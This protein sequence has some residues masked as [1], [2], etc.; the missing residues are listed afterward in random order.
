M[1]LRLFPCPAGLGAQ[2]LPPFV[3]FVSGV[4]LG[5]FLNPSGFAKKN[6]SLGGWVSG[7]SAGQAGQQAGQ[8]EPPP[9][10]PTQGRQGRHL[11]AP[12]PTTH[13]TPPPK[14]G[15]AGD[16][17]TTPPTTQGRQS[18]HHQ[19]PKPA[20]RAIKP[21]K[22]P[23]QRSPASIAP[24]PPKPAPVHET[25]CFYKGLLAGFNS[26]THH[27]KQTTTPQIKPA[28]R[29]KAGRQASIKPTPPEAR[30]AKQGTRGRHTLNP[31]QQHT[32]PA[33]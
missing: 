18:R 30:R 14:A 32:P 24:N 22:S 33:I 3:S 2:T 9:P 10:N 31:K 6:F 29:A 1:C 15:R 21:E 19:N 12:N 5:S 27:P 20:E 13:P 17:A 25:R 23:H 28:E 8:Q 11:H 26:C 4:L 7:V 16:G